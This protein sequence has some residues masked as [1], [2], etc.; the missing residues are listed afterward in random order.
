MNSPSAQNITLLLQ[1]WSQGRTDALEKLLPLVYSELHR[2]AHYYM[3]AERTGHMLQTT[4]LI[5][6]AFLRMV[7]TRQAHP[8]N[9][10]YFFALSAQMMRRVL[11][12]YARNQHCQKRGGE[13][14]PITLEE[15]CLL[16]KEP[17][18]NLV[19]LDEALSALSELDVRKSQVVELRY[20]GG[21]SVNETAT[22]LNVSSDTVMRD[23]QFAKAWLLR[24]IMRGKVHPDSKTKVAEQEY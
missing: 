4:A 8:S 13:M 12:D 7:D 17:D 5:N 24:Y 21:L 22:V 11:V 1:E 23:W 19:A 18:P 10:S 3:H 16:P 9:R 2:L 6:E 20:F 15:A 14:I